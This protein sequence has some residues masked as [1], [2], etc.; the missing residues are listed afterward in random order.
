MNLRMFFFR[1]RGF[2]QKDRAEGDLSSELRTHLELLEQ[3]NVRQGMTPEEARYAAR[4]EFGGV[5]QTKEAYR[6]QRSLPF[7]DTLMQD[8]RFA[9]R[10]LRKYPVFAFVAVLTLSGGAGISH[11][12][13]RVTTPRFDCEKSPSSEGP[14]PHRPSGPAFAP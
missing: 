10:G 4:R 2:F 13:I 8:L 1:L 11:T 5:E 14:T 6:Q 12:V 7:L 3:E 9:V